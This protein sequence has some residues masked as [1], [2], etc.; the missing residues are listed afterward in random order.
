MVIWVIGLAGSGKSTISKI[1]HNAFLKSALP[2]VLVDGDEIRK[3]F[4]NDLGHSIKDRLKNASRIRELCKLLDKSR[5]NAVCAI[6]SISELDRKWCRENLSS[7][8]EIYI[9]TPLPLIEKRGYRDLY[10]KYDQGL[11]IDVVGKDIKFDK[12][13]RPDFIINNDK[14]KEVFIE[15]G[16]KIANTILQNLNEL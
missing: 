11:V 5:I 4:G 1:I 9:N 7:Y 3:I 15:E 12:P 2:T 13:S 10:L 8:I 14:S 16:K 6:L